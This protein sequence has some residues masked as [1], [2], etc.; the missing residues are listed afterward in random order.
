MFELRYYLLTLSGIFLALGIGILIG[1]SYGEDA[2]IYSQ[3]EVINQLEDELEMV[4]RD[5]REINREMKRWHEFQP[6]FWENI[7]TELDFA[8][9]PVGLVCSEEYPY[10]ELQQLLEKAGVKYWIITVN[11]ELEKT[12]K[13]LSRS[14]LD[15]ST[16]EAREKGYQE[17]FEELNKKKNGA[18]SPQLLWSWLED[19]GLIKIY[20]KYRSS[21][22]VFLLMD[23]EDKKAE[24]WAEKKREVLQGEKDQV[25]AL[26]HGSPAKEPPFSI[27]G[28]KEFH[29]EN[30]FWIKLRILEIIRKS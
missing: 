6:Y 12:W 9:L 7:Y 18:E 5:K 1:I 8:D 2:L 10:Q 20:G 24:T 17:F 22:K 13:E 23:T 27:N 28:D 16:K 26:W 3:Q 19:K 11:P 30:L 14:E 4:Y 21:E 25:I 29:E 15:W